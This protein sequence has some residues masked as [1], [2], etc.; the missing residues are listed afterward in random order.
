VGETVRAFTA[1]EVSERCVRA[2]SAVRG[3][4]AD[5]GPSVRWVRAENLH[6]TLRFLGEVETAR[7]DAYGAA[8]H[9]A[10][11]AFESFDFEVAGLGAFPARGVPRVIFAAMSR[12]AETMTA[13]VGALSREIEPLGHPPEARPFHPH[14]TLGRTRGAAPGIRGLRAA[15]DRESRF[16]PVLE[17]AERIALVRSRRTPRGSIYDTLVAAPLRPSCPEND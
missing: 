6:V 5:A 16:A 13:L 9:R 10:A 8:L 2:L 14:V 11:S 12:G 3:R 15:L 4:L 7:L 1:I 17:R